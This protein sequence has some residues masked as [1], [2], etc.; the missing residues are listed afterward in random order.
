[1]RLLKRNI[2]AIAIIPVGETRRAGRGETSA[3]Y[4]PSFHDIVTDCR[5]AAN[6]RAYLRHCNLDAAALSISFSCASGAASK[7][8]R[9]F[10]AVQDFGLEV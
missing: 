3:Q 9:G 10:M 2:F 6:Q 7:D 4:V 5:V 1:M 8:K